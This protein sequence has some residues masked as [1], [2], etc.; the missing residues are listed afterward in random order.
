MTAITESETETRPHWPYP[1]A[2]AAAAASGGLAVLSLAD[3]TP[4]WGPVYLRVIL[5]ALVAAGGLWLAIVDARTYRLPNEIV[6]PLGI[7]VL[8]INFSLAIA[9]GDLD[10]LLWSAAGA[11]GMGL[12]YLL[13][14]LGGGVGLGDVK[15]AAVLGLYLGWYGWEAPVAAT[16]A[17]YLLAA[18][19][20]IAVTVIRRRHPERN[21]RVAFGPYLIAG[22][23]I[24][25]LGQMLQ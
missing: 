24:V 15:L 2:I 4:F 3:V 5:F 21:P 7:A 20:A 9:L 10:R 11:L 22:A 1:V 8:G 16:V 25:A 12:F 18:P 17:A 23:V 19:Q 6:Y 13:L 14:G